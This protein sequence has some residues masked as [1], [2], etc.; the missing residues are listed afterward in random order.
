MPRHFRKYLC[1]PVNPRGIKPG[2][3][4]VEPPVRA[5]ENLAPDVCGIKVRLGYRLP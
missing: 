2:G 5:S 3:Q 4:E 1:G